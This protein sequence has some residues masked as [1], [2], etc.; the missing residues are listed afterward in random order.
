MKTKAEPKKT[1][2]PSLP[3]AEKLVVVPVRMSPE[4]KAKFQRL[5]N[6]PQRFR[7]WLDRVKE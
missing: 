7:G 2:R 1:G 6:G 3:P 4:Q 5:A